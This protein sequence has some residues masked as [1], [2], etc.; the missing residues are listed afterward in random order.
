MGRRD[1]QKDPR[2]P[3]GRVELDVEGQGASLGFVP[4]CQAYGLRLLDFGFLQMI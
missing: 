3:T 4:C 2:S 1:E